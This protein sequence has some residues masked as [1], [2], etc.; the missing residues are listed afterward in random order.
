M[1]FFYKHSTAYEMRISDWSSDVCSSDL[2]M[3]LGR[4][5]LVL[6]DGAAHLLGFVDGEEI[7]NLRLHVGTLGQFQAHRRIRRCRQRLGL[8]VVDTAV[9]H[10]TASSSGSGAM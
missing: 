7:Q 3:G 2:Q 6:D 8:F 1:F 9:G 10:F 5:R 4:R